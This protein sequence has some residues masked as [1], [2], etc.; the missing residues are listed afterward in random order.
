[1]DI[2][3]IKFVRGGELFEYDVY[4]EW[5]FFFVLFDIEE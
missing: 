5:Y 1:M 2:L 4:R 3:E